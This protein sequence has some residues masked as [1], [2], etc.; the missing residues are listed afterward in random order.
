MSLDT[1]HITL[2]KVEAILRAATPDNLHEH[3]VS[4][5]GWLIHAAEDYVTEALE[6]LNAEMGL[7]PEEE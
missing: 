2:K 3:D 7:S 6:D 5:M 4:R 1:L